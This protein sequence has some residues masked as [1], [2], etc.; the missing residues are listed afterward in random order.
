EAGI[1][2]IDFYIGANPKIIYNT[3]ISKYHTIMM[4][5]YLVLAKAILRSALARRESRGAHYRTDF[6]ET[7][8]EFCAPSLAKFQDGQIHICFETEAH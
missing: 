8:P 7:A 3:V 6:P 1:A 4:E 5:Q 2:E